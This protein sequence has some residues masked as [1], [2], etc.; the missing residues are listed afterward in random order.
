[1][2]SKNDSEFFA[3]F[4]FFNTFQIHEGGDTNNFNTENNFKNKYQDPKLCLGKE[5]E[6]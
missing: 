2:N 3:V 6:S 4:S 5:F 1:M